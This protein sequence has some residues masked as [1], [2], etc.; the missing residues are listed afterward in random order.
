MATREWLGRAKARAEV[1]TIQVTAY[2]AATTYI[3]TVNGKSVTAI[4]AGSV[5]AT[6]TALA[7]AWNAA[8]EA[9]F[10][11]I[12]ASANTDTVTLTHDTAGVPFTVTT[13]ESGG[14]GTIGNPSTTTAATGPNHWDDA[15]NWS[16]GA[17]PVNSDD[18]YV[19]SPVAILY[20]LDQ[21][22]VTLA[23]LT[24]AASFT[25]TIGLPK[26]RFSGYTEY[27]DDYLQISASTVKIGVGEGQGSGRIKLNLGSVQ[28]AIEVR[29][30]AASAETGTPAILLLGTNASNVLDVQGGSS[31][32]L[33]AFSGEVSTVATLTAVA[34]ASVYC[35]E[36]CTLTTVRGDGSITLNSAATTV[37]VS[38]GG[39]LVMNGSGAVTTLNVKEDG[40]CY[41]RSSGTVTT[42]N[43]T[44]A[45]D[46]STDASSR[47]F[48]TTNLKA[49]G[50]IFDP[51][52]TITYTNGIAVDDSVREIQAS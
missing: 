30:S 47:T 18:V 26:T 19:A 14:T 32:G 10:A 31:V 24:I 9:E 27:R 8:T 7:S 22:A 16:G 13:D 20:G 2:D 23:S 33:A 28:A 41:Y 42:A 6:A 3:I 39:V 45:V 52:R 48:T 25:E 29:K 43:I 51:Q 36:G 21:S 46:C 44:G 4:A 40:L 35:G 49:R 34:G 50:R 38:A 1:Q 37:T 11:E 12:T 5:N 17:V 15:S